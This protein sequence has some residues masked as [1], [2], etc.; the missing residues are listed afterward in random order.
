VTRV[1]VFAEALRYI[2][3]G[4]WRRK[5]ETITTKLLVAIVTVLALSA[6]LANAAPQKSKG[7]TVQKTSATQQDHFRIGY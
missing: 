7:Y 4:N 2:G 1:T 5:T 3:N 6:S